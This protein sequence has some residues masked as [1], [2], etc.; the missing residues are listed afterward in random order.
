MIIIHHANPFHIWQNQYFGRRALRGKPGFCRPRNTAAMP[1]GSGVF[2]FYNGAQFLAAGPRGERG[3][4][5]IPGPAGPQGPQGIQGEQGPQGPQ[6]PAGEFAGE[7]AY[8]GRYHAGSQAVNFNRNGGPVQVQ[9]DS[10]MP[11]YHVSGDG[12]N[13]LIIQEDGDYRVT[14]NLLLSSN[15]PVQVGAVVRKNG[16]AIPFTQG[17]QATAIDEAS[18][19]ANNARLTAAAIVN[20]QAGDALDLAVSAAGTP[21]PDLNTVIEGYANAA[22]VAEKL[23]NP[24]SAAAPSE[25]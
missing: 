7:L 21:P 6:G 16:E 13:R 17:S 10:L 12:S 9:L 25:E 11:S 3:E 19:S 18:Q 20:L 5:G 8:G 15:Y 1:A 22:L 24:F 14:Y 2:G 4:R 23:G